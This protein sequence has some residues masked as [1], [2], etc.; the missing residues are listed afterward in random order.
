MRFKN[1]RLKFSTNLVDSIKK[2]DIVFICVGTPTKKNGTG[3]DLTQIFSAA[4]EIS[5]SIN[6]FN[7]LITQKKL[8]KWYFPAHR[9]LMYPRAKVVKT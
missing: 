8:F 3:A 1:K 2:S 5:K 7:S 9:S 6:K 4:K